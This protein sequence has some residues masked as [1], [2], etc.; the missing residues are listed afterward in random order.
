MKAKGERRSFTED[1][2]AMADW[3]A[4]CG[5]DT[6]VMESTGVYWI[7]PYELLEARGF[8]VYLVNARHVKNVSGKKS[9]V[10]DCQ[11]VR[12]AEYRHECRSPRMTRLCDTPHM[13]V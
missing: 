6:V 8:T 9:D 10:F 3:L 13:G 5:I 1:L 12:T 7:A 11:W 4:E 2:V